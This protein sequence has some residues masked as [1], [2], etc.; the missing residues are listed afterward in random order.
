MFPYGKWNIL[1]NIWS[2]SCLLIAWRHKS[3]GYQQIWYGQRFGANP[4]YL[5]WIPVGRC[6]AKTFLKMCCNSGRKESTH[7]LTLSGQ[8]IDSESVEIHL[9][10]MVDRESFRLELG[11][12]PRPSVR[13]TVSQFSMCR[14]MR[15]KLN[16]CNCETGHAHE[17]YN[18]SSISDNLIYLRKFLNNL[19]WEW[20]RV[21]CTCVQITKLNNIA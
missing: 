7:Y 14:P 17:W 8:N 10:Y 21:G 9:F 4:V 11:H 16:C 15:F 18:A 13:P 1:K 20:F 5:R 19:N 12:H 6:N 2:I 3:P